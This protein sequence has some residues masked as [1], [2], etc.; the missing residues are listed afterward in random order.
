MLGIWAGTARGESAKFWLQILSELKNRGVEDIFFPVR[1][2]LKGMPDSVVTAFP[3]TVVQTCIIHLIRQT[4]RYA[5]KKYWQQI[6]SNL[7]PIYG[8]A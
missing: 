2:G 8:A 7:K 5:S 3:A 4:F 1:D 6:A